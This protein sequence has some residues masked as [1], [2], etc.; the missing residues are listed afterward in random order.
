MSSQPGAEA[1]QFLTLSGVA[2]RRSSIRTAGG[3]ATRM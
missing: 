3:I 1:I 2:G